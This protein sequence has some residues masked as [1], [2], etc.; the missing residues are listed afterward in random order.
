MVKV[1]HGEELEQY[2]R[3]EA[4]RIGVPADGMFVQTFCLGYMQGSLTMLKQ[5]T[6]D[7]TVRNVKVGRRKK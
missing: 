2:A 1:L 3:S 4:K 6:R 5:C 7:V